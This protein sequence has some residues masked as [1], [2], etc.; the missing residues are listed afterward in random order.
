MNNMKATFIVLSILITALPASGQTVHPSGPPQNV[1]PGDPKINAEDL[2]NLDGLTQQQIENLGQKVAPQQLENLEDQLTPQQMENLKQLFGIQ[3]GD[4]PNIP[5]H[6]I[7]DWVQKLQADGVD[8]SKLPPDVRRQTISWLDQR[9]RT[10]RVIEVENPPYLL[11]PGGPQPIAGLP[12]TS[13]KQQFI[14]P[15]AVLKAAGSVGRIEDSVGNLVG[16]AWVVKEGIVATNCHVALQLLG[17]GGGAIPSETVVDFEAKDVHSGSGH[18]FAITNALFVS[19]QKGLDIAL[20]TV[21][22]TS[23]NSRAVLPPPL[24]LRELDAVPVGGYFVGYA[25]GTQKSSSFDTDQLRHALSKL[26]KSAK[27]SS[28]VDLAAL[29]SFSDFGVVLH[30][31]STHYG[32]SGSPLLDASGQVVAVH[33]CCNVASDFIG[34]DTCASTTVVT[35]YNNQAITAGAFDTVAEIKKALTSLSK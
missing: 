5:V 20:L 19:K 35:P 32:S 1:S 28:P 22:K 4:L 10:Q 18:K 14:V 3:P 2:R 13:T 33:D 34:G 27:I 15:P 25:S 21:N 6:D 17:A 29:V 26:G 16:T 24:T 11:L 7:A 12:Y 8:W 9:V 31:A 30:N 23:K